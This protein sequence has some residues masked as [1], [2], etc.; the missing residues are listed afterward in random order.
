MY[1]RRPDFFREEAPPGRQVDAKVKW[2]NASKGFG[3]VTMADGSQD[4]FLPMAILRRAGY[5]DVR[6]GASITCEVSPGAKGPLVTNVLN[7]DNSTAVAPG[8][9]FDR[10]PQRPATVMEGAVKWFEPDKG[11]GFISPDGGGK[12]VFIHITALRRSG[13][14]ALAPGQRVRVDVVDGKKGLEADRLTLI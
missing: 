10:R 14:N 1:D 11:Y 6:E 4:A 12:D 9:G 5:E 8:A 3:F 13:V 2:F 7:I